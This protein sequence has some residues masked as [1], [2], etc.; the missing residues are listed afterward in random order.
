MDNLI[1]VGMRYG[2]SSFSQEL[3]SYNTGTQGQYWP[4]NSN[5][6]PTKYDNLNASWLSGLIGLKV[7]VFPH[8][9]IGSSFQINRLISQTAPTNFQNLF[10]PGYNKMGLNDLSVSFNYTVSYL[11]PFS[12]KEKKQDE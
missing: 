1:Y 8:L 10:A 11:I 7:E 2:H 4:I 5:N 3:L 12:K 9:F 6:I